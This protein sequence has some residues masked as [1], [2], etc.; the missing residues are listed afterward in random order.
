MGEGLKNIARAAGLV[1]ALTGVADCG[2]G[3]RVTRVE[4]TPQNPCPDIGDGSK[5][6]DKASPEEQ[7]AIDDYKTDFCKHNP[8]QCEDGKYNPK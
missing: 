4:C 5:V 8:S 7:R 3:S 2:S 1:T 6:G